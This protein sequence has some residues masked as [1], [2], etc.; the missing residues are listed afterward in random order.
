LQPGCA[1]TAASLNSVTPVVW[2]TA[3]RFVFIEQDIIVRFGSLLTV[4][5][6]LLAIVV[7]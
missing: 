3:E 6:K 1:D 7:E 4:V 5:A 2:F